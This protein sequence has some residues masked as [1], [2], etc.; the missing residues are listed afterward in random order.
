MPEN[1]FM[2]KFATRFCA[3]PCPSLRKGVAGWLLGASLLTLAAVP[4]WAESRA[5]TNG[6]PNKDL[7]HSSDSGTIMVIYPEANE[8]YRG[9][10]AQI[11]DGIREK[12]KGRVSSF[13]IGDNVN[14]GELNNALRRQNTRVVIALGRQSIMATI[15]LADGIDVIAGGVLTATENEARSMQVNILSPD[16]R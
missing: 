12:A 9:M 4:A 13:S 11:V 16:R 7:A 2:W 8:P 1:Y 14:T 5:A 10:F 6:S 15:A 3:T